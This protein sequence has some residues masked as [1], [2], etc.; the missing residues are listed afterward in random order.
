[1][2]YAVEESRV[3]DFINS[4]ISLSR[5][6]QSTRYFVK[7]IERA[8]L[9]LRS[10]DEKAPKMTLSE[11]ARRT[12]ISRAS[13]RRILLSLVDL[14]YAEQEN[15]LFRLSPR[16]LD[17]G[18]AFLS[19]QGLAVL[20]QPVLE[21]LSSKLQEPVSLAVLDG[22][23][24]V[25]IARASYAR[26]VTISIGI[27]SRLPAYVT[28]LGRV[29]LAGLP[30]QTRDNLLKSTKPQKYTQNTV[31]DMAELKRIVAGVKSKQFSYLN[32][33]LEVGLKALAVPVRGSSSSVVA[34]IGISAYSAR[35]SR[36]KLIDAWLPELRKAAK[37]I[38]ESLAPSPGRD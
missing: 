18:R 14:G 28:A 6:A 10:F 12:N 19:S 7:S 13:A 4:G 27:G 9:V 22:T 20:A 29:L 21:H 26:F 35:V 23:D 25:Y 34:A 11:V 38:E 32:E 5:P 24:I 17:L 15:S 31:T 36:N 2:R 33:E 37:K 16:V 8:L 1:M 3:A 30:E